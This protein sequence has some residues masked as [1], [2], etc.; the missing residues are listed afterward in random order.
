MSLFSS[1]HACVTPVSHSELF[2]T[3]LHGGAAGRHLSNLLPCMSLL[4]AILAQAL[5]PH[6]HASPPLATG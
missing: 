1:M 2:M 3:L 5:G 4:G 6:V